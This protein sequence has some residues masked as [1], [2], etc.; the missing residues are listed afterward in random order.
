M[1]RWK[2]LVIATLSLL[3][4]AAFAGFGAWSLYESGRWFW[5]WWV[6]PVCWG[7]SSLLWRWWWADL[8]IPLPKLDRPHWTP[9]DETA[10][11]IVRR[12]QERVAEFPAAQLT[13]PQF[14]TR[15]TQELALDI[16][17]HYH[18]RA[19]DPLGSLSVVE[20]LAAVQLVS[21]D[22]ED[23][24][25]KYVPASHLVTVS[26]WRLLSKAPE[27]YQT[28][29]NAGWAASILLNPLNIA[30][31]FVSQFAVAPLAQQLQ[32][33]LLGTFY[34]LYV[35]QAGYYLIELNSG[36]LRG[37]SKRYREW[38]RQLHGT[39]SPPAAAMPQATAAT[40]VAPV[41]ITLAVIG[42]VKAGKSSLVNCLL[43]GQQAATD[44]LPATKQ[45]QRFTL[46]WPER[47]E[48][49]VLLDTP[50]YSDAGATPEQL[51][52]T[53]EAARQADL[54]LLVLD[55]RSPAKEADA[56]VLRDLREW[57]ATQ[58]RLK[59]PP[60]VAVLNK[61]DGLS[62][63]LEWSPPYDW[64][65]PVRP[66]ARNIAAAVEYARELF[67]TEAVEFVPICADR[68]HGRD[69]GIAEDLLPAM[70][71]HLDAAR[72]AALVRGLHGDF[73]KQKFRQVLGQVLEAGKQAM[74]FVE[75][76]RK[77]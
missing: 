20:I 5:L 64:K 42:Q 29:V 6:L 72:V 25:L 24:F 30:R 71:R 62:P 60:I 51:R 7:L 18:P 53:R 27:W 32:Q 50:G 73:D 14:Y 31:Y 56:A 38:M 36:R 43:G 37:G 22:V 68:D 47:S 67:G 15:I 63:V 75:T 65:S 8:K 28:A 17:K 13:D 58:P 41:T 70:A 12:T 26:H 55:V 74:S 16:A 23:W 45:V 39:E 57:F 52:E 11:A 46:T 1:S 76:L 77:P 33:N 21:E 66:K 69:T 9:Q 4:V 19:A 3:P 34:T 48:Q 40:D 54:L 35:R 59:P 10:M 49:L 61:I 2:L 44:V